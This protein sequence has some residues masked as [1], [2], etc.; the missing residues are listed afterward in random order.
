M[1]NMYQDIKKEYETVK[2]PEALKAE[3]LE[4][5]KAEANISKKK[6][7]YRYPVVA[8]AACAAVLC[9]VLFWPRGV[10]YITPI[11]DGTY[12]EEIAIKN[13][14]IIFNQNRV[15]I[16]IKPNAGKVVIGGEKAEEESEIFAVIKEEQ[17]SAGG[18]L[19]CQ[20]VSSLSLPEIRED[21]WSNIGQQQIYVTVLKTDNYRFQA[22]YEKEGAAYEVI[23]TGVTQK[24]F[25][26]FL[27]AQIK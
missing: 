5:M 23:G 20:E 3:T 6:K 15:A 21:A 17:T 1:D 26:D 27:Y 10:R 8:L 7:Y 13:G 12:Y 16:S 11:E 14:N 25:I 19:V 2:A 4:K 9:F 18:E 22:A 24:E